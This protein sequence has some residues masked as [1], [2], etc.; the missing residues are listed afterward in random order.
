M[1]PAGVLG[2][3]LVSLLGCTWRVD[4]R[5]DRGFEKA[6]SDG[7][8]F[9]YC[10][11][12][13]RMLPLAWTRRGEGIAVLVS[14]HRDGELIARVIVSLGFVLGRGSSTRGGGVGLREMLAWGERGHALGFTPDG[15]RGP[16]EVAKAGVAYAAARLG[17]RIV[18]IATSSAEAWVARS[19]DGFRI[20]KPFSRVCIAHGT[21]LPPPPDAE[22]A[23]ILAC[24][25]RVERALHALTRDVARRSGEIP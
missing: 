14:R 10:V 18:P 17:W 11:W 20:P 12:H 2:G 23:S 6:R 8:R 1:G 19:W 21:P 3:G 13:A 24:R 7:E 15:P 25:E 4:E 9:I 5:N 22:E 16:A